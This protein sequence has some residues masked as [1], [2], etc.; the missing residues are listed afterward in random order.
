[1]SFAYRIHFPDNSKGSSVSGTGSVGSG[2]ASVGSGGALHA[3]KK[4][5]VIITIITLK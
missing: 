1:M 2:R 4:L 3:V 5:A